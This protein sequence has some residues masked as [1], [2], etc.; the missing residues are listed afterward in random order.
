MG[1]TGGCAAECVAA[2]VTTATCCMMPVLP[3][4]MRFQKGRRHLWSVHAAAARTSAAAFTCTVILARLGLV[5]ARA[6]VW[7]LLLQQYN[8]R[9]KSE[10]AFKSLVLNSKLISV[11]D[12]ESYAE[13]FCKSAQDLF[14]ARGMD[15]SIK[16]KFEPNS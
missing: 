11:M 7:V 9:K 2:D 15:I 14:V 3:F 16:N 5:V 1:Y 10:H 12:P 13:R 6:K 8:L 4:C